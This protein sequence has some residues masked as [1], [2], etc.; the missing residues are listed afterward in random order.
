MRASL[1]F[2][3]LAL[4][5]CSDGEAH[6]AEGA[7]TPAVA[8]PPER[9]EATTEPTAP[10]AAVAEEPAWM[11]A[12][13]ELGASTDD[14]RTYEHV[15]ALTDASGPRLAGS[16]GDRLAVAWALAALPA[17]GLSNVRSEP[18]TV[19]VWER[20]DERLDV[21]S[22]VPHRLAM[23]ALGGSVGTPARGIEAELVR[24][25]SLDAL[26]AADRTAIEGR[27]VFVDQ[28]M[29]RSRDGHGYGDAIGVRIHA[30]S[31]S[32][33]RGALA[34]L[35]RSIG[36]DATRFPHTGVMRYADDA[37]RIPA[38]AIANADADFLGRTMAA[39]TPVR[40][41]LT[42]GCRDAGEAQSANVIAEVPGTDRASEIVLLG[43]HL[44]SW[45]LGRG[46]ID[47]GAG[48][49]IIVEVARRLATASVRPRRTIRI[50]LYAN[51]ENGGAGAEAYVVAH[52][53]ELP[54]HVV[55]F[56]ADFGDG[57]VWGLRSP[58][59][60]A[61][62]EAW[63]RVAELLEPLE[64]A[65]DLGVPEGGAD[66]EDLHEV[67]VPA[68]E[69][70]QDGSRYFDLHHTANDVMTE[71]DRASLDD[72]MRAYLVVAY[73]A[74]LDVDGIT[75][76]AAD[77]PTPAEPPPDEPLVAPSPPDPTTPTA[78]ETP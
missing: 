76:T 48:V 57:R 43:A 60:P 3:A 53:A 13:R 22:P 54:Q 25:E 19:R 34:V 41:H 72:A 49:G 26:R 69:L 37:P 50:V 71:V 32:A 18:V 42:L 47:D 62:S 15:R 27:I 75:R 10:V 59:A 74:A 56:E 38:A 28:V 11:A 67:G 65:W 58:D 24:F 30:A 36:T 39:G 70:L 52:A 55:A 20:G 78:A 8:M 23:A 16:P 2:F 73:A 21:V 77:V 64:V 44:D 51:E 45:D 9:A 14:L 1:V 7:G 6:V 46:A 66:I 29:E 68:L 12:V 63:T 40:V 33:T 31:E 4:L 35:I 61:R 5:A 17:L